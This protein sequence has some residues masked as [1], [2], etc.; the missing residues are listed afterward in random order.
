MVKR[1]LRVVTRGAR[2]QDGLYVVRVDS[3]GPR[4][5]WCWVTSAKIHPSALIWML[6]MYMDGYSGC[7]NGSRSE[8]RYMD[9]IEGKDPRLRSERCVCDDGDE[10]ES[11]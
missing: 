2:K 9:C 4:E 3:N 11:S 7:E 10:H 8:V 5:S 6:L 1:N